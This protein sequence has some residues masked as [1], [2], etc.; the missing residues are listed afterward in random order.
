MFCQITQSPEIKW[1]YVVTYKLL[2]MLYFIQICPIYSYLWIYNYFQ[3]R[4]TLDL[5]FANVPLYCNT[6][7]VQTTNERALIGKKD[8]RKENN[9]RLVVFLHIWINKVLLNTQW[10][11]NEFYVNKHLASG[12]GVTWRTIFTIL[13][14]VENK[15]ISFFS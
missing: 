6:I 9:H 3:V 4:T 12:L 7:L 8:R 2:Q 13:K 5:Q 10:Q 15:Y 14:Y 11:F 1:K